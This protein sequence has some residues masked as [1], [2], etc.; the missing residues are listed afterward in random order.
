MQSGLR[1]RATRS[2]L[3]LSASLAGLAALSLGS[4]TRAAVVVRDQWSDGTRTDPAAPVYS[5]FGVDGDLDGNL[6]SAWYNAGTGATMT[7][8][9]GHLVLA[10]ASASSASWTTFYTPEASPI[11]LANTGDQLKITWAFT[12]QGVNTSN[13]SQNFR[14]AVMQTPAGSR[15]SSDA[16]PNT[17]TY[18]SPG[19]A[20]Y[21]MFMNMGQTTGNGNSF[22]LKKR[23]VVTSSDILATSGNWGT[24]LANGLGNGAVGYASG[25]QYTFTET[26]TRNAANGLDI[27]ATMAGGTIGGTGLVT[28]SATD[29][30]PAGFT[31]DT[32]TLRPSTPET[33]ATSFDTTLFQVEGPVPE[34]ASLALLGLGSVAMLRRRRAQ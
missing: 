31:F 18:G 8:S 20:A 17:A 30:T 12:P 13:T 7:P 5:E 4:I 9:V 33:T 22:N 19:N 10:A 14:M 11:T 3:V 16:A 23:S 15:I 6:E 29:A 21:A 2:R 27:V 1:P 26:F 25:T 32:F 28:A 24:S 34:P